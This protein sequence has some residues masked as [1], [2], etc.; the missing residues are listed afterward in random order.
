MLVNS[1]HKDPQNQRNILHVP[2]LDSVD[3]LDGAAAPTRLKIMRTRNMS[4]STMIYLVY[5]VLRTLAHT[6][7]KRMNLPSN[8]CAQRITNTLLRQVHRRVA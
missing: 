1:V 5:T 6:N 4:H 8:A 3:Y 2:I 7:L